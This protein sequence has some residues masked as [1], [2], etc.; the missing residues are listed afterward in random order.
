MESVQSC[1]CKHW[2]RW[3]QIMNVNVK[4]ALMT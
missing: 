1:Y 4:S 2:T 3:V